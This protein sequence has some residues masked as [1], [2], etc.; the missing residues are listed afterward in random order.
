[1]CCD[2]EAP[3]MTGANEAARMTA[4]DSRRY[5]D[6]YLTVEQPWQR[7]ITER[8]IGTY[9]K[10]AESSRELTGY[11]LGM[12]KR[13]DERYWDVAVPYEDQLLKDVERFD[14]AEY[15]QQQVDSALADVG[16]QFD[17]AQEQ[18][19]RG[20][21]RRGINPNSGAFA[22]MANQNS[23]AKAAAMA[24]AANKTRQAAEQVGL[25]TKMQMY[26]GMKGLAG[27]GATNA[28]LA[29]SG[30][31]A[32]NSSAGGMT[33]AANSYIASG[34][35]VQ[36]T[37]SSGMGTAMNGWIGAGNVTNAAN[38]NDPMN[39]VLGAAAG[40]GTSYALGKFK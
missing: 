39:A 32:G 3:D 15:K 38:A 11:Q 13:N 29:T 19:I 8:A 37:F 36:G 7:N 20:M 17:A 10:N 4:E 34:A 28:G 5:L 27:L 6:N 12:M 16:G 26:G 2:N 21:Q 31:G 23:I 18:S 33:N 1:M 14:S 24:S 30:I 25:S 9:E 35:G 22:A 40:V